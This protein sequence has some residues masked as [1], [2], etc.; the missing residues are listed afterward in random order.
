MSSV[1]TSGRNSRASCSPSSPLA[2]D[3]DPIAFLRQEGLQQVLNHR[4][5]VDH[6][7]RRR[8]A[9][10]AGRRR[11][12]AASAAACADRLRVDHLARQPDGERRALAQLA[13]HRDVPPIISQNLRVIVRPRPVPPYLRVVDASAWVK[14]SNTFATCSGVIP[15]PES[16][17][18]NS[19]SR[20]PA[21]LFR[22]DLQLDDAL[23][24]ELA[25]VA[26]QVEH[27]LPHLGHIGPHVHDFRREWTVSR[28]AFLSTSGFMVVTRR[29]TIS[30]TRSLPG[31]DPSSRPRS[32]RGRE[33][34]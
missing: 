7:D 17:T 29:C 32:W 2:R 14:A 6:Q 8:L 11:L 23:R 25:G 28:L 12:A 26:Q 5:V 30:W 34:R 16:F 22:R 15:M 1:I 4:I 3:R 13:R 24:R 18:A 21:D 10:V 20:P 27:P 19:H 9:A 31:R 33:C